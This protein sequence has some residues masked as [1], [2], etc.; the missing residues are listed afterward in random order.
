MHT[1]REP[2]GGGPVLSPQDRGL[3]WVGQRHADSK[4]V[5]ALRTA[6]QG[7]ALDHHHHPLVGPIGHPRI[8]AIEAGGHLGHADLQGGGPPGDAGF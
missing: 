6:P 8:Q 7:D 1:A 4:T 2:T 3:P 5:T